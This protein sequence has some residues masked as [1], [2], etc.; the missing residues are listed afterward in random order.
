M[1][2]IPR[3][4]VITLE[5]AAIWLRVSAETI[6]KLAERRELP[7][8]QVDSEWRFFKPALED[9]LRGGSGKAALLLQAGAFADD[10]SLPELLDH[11]YQ[12]RGRPECE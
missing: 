4:E 12:Q 9:W 6:L 10:D 7:G 11:I 3:E 1:A 8:R 2:T 5:E